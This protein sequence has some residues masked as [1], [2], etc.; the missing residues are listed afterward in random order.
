MNLPYKS[1]PK[2]IKYFD[3]L[4]RIW[5]NLKYSNYNIGSFV[6]IKQS[7]LMEAL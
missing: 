6:Y 7:I 3:N 4:S 1:K 5:M 2:T